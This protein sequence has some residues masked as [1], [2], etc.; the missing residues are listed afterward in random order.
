MWIKILHRLYSLPLVDRFMFI[1]GIFTIINIPY[2][3]ILLMLIG[4]FT[5]MYLQEILE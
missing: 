2:P 5:G 1:L 4:L 3:A